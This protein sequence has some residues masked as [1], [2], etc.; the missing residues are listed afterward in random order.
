MRGQTTD[1]ARFVLAASLLLGLALVLGVSSALG[2]A[3]AMAI[4]AW[5]SLGLAISMRSMSLRSTN[6]RQ[7]LSMDS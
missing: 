5:V 4:S 3:L 1:R 7:S 6:A 2:G